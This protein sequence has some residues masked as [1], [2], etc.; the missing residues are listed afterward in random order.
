[1]RKLKSLSNALKIVWGHSPFKFW[2]FFC[3]FG[4]ALG[5]WAGIGMTSLVLLVAIA[6]LGWALE[7]ANTSIETLLDIVNPTYSEK[8]RVVK[9]LYCAVPSFVYFAYVVSWLILVAPS[10]YL[11][12]MS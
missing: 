1:M 4:V 6:C 12:V 7:T 5:L 11:K 10:L 9:D 2:V 8:V 3:T